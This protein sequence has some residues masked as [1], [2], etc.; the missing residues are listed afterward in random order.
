[1]R[2]TRQTQDEPQF[3]SLEDESYAA[4]LTEDMQLFGQLDA[5]Q[6]DSDLEF[7]ELVI[8]V[9]LVELIR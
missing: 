3:V 6:L 1:M 9:G 4:C 7:V 8:I 2:Q 5:L